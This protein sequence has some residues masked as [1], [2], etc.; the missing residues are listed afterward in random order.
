[1]DGFLVGPIRV[2]QMLGV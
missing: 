1:M 2:C